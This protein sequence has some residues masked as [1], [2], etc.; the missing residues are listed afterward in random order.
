MKFLVPADAPGPQGDDRP[1][2][3]KLILLII[4]LAALL[5]PAVVRAGDEG[6]VYVPLSIREGRSWFR[7]WELEEAMIELGLQIPQDTMFT[8]CILDASADPD[9][10]DIRYWRCYFHR[11]GDNLEYVFRFDHWSHKVIADG[12]A[13]AN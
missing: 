7:Q 4:V 2:C 12:R 13:P 8:W 1:G 5:S 3:F 10:G 9:R 11:P 6:T